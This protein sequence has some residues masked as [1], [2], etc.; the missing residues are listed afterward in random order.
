MLFMG[1]LTVAIA[2]VGYKLYYDS[3]MDSYITYADTV[4]EYAYRATE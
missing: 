4:L 2:V 3:V 1:I